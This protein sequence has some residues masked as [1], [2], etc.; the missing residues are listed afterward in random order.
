MGHRVFQLA[1][2]VALLLGGASL[3]VVHHVFYTLLN[4]KRIDPKATELPSFLRDQNNVNFIGTTIAHGARIMLSM[5]IGGTFCQLFW[6]RLRSRSHTIAQIDAI[7]SCGQSPF[8]PS[9]LRAAKACFV[10]FMISL[11]AST[12]AL[13]VVLSPGSLTIS[14]DAQLRRPCTV[15]S[16]PKEITSS[17]YKF[18]INHPIILRTILTSISSS[19]SYLPPLKNNLATTCGDDASSCSYNVTLVGPAL[20]CIDITNETD[21]SS[22]HNNPDGAS[23]NVPFPIWETSTNIGDAVGITISSRDMVRGLLQ[24]NNCSAYNATYDVG[25]SVGE[26]SATAHVWSVI[27]DRVLLKD[28]SFISNYAQAALQLLEGY[29]YTGPNVSTIF[30]QF[31]SGPFFVMTPLGNHTFSDT[32]PHFVISLMQN[33]SISLLSGNIYY[34]LSNDTAT[35]YQDINS[36]AQD[37]KPEQTFSMSD[38]RR[39][40]A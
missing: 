31:P 4:E 6:E 25:V 14:T 32:V 28:D 19:N 40:V 10:L 24:A 30:G 8:R 38:R 7:V 34:G 33:V 9:A 20:D 13:I 11:T 23:Q 5:A 15:P 39:S 2:L 37:P 27:R 12:T 3:M 36:T 22:F 35:N 17:D 18:E 1:P 21:F 29:A 16:V 26:S